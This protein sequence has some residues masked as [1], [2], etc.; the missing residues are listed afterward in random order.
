MAIET[1]VLPN[2]ITLYHIAS[3]VTLETYCESG[4]VISTDNVCGCYVYVRGEM[5]VQY[6]RL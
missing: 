5:T 3:R 6:L 2:S 4:D 1:L